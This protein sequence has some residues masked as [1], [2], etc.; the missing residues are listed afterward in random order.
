[1]KNRALAIVL[2]VATLISSVAVPV[3]ADDNI[4]MT[5]V[6]RTDIKEEKSLVINGF[7]TTNTVNEQGTD[8]SAT[9]SQ[10][11]FSGVLSIDNQGILDEITEEEI[12]KAIETYNSLPE[13][14][15]A[16]YKDAY[17]AVIRLTQQAAVSSE[18]QN[19]TNNNVNENNKGQENLVEGV[20]LENK[21]TDIL[22]LEK[23][24]AKPSKTS[25]N[26]ITVTQKGKILIE[27]PKSEKAVGYEFELTNTKKDGVGTVYTSD[28]NKIEIE[29]E[30][31]S[32][33]HVRVRSFNQNGAG[34]VY[35]AWSMPR[36]Y[37][38]KV[39]SLDKTHITA[40]E[41]KNNYASLTFSE[42]KN[43]DGIEVQAA[44]D[45]DFK[46]I[47]YTERT[48]NDYSYRT[49]EVEEG[50]TIY[51]RGRAYKWGSQDALTSEW[52]DVVTYVRERKVP[53]KT[54]LTSVKGN[55][56]RINVVWAKAENS[57]SYDVEIAE[58]KHF[59]KI[60]AS[61][62]TEANH[63]ENVLE[64]GKKYCVRVRGTR[65]DWP[66]LYYGEWSNV[67]NLT[68]NPSAVNITYLKSNDK[69]QATIKYKPLKSTNTSGYQIQYSTKKNFDN[70][71]IK[72]LA[73]K[74]MTIKKLKRGK[75]YYF[76]VRQYTVIEGKKVYGVWS[77][78][79]SV[80][81]KKKTPK[82]KIR[83]KT[84][85]WLGKVSNG[86]VIYIPGLGIKTKAYKEGSGVDGQVIVDRRGSCLY[87]KPGYYT[88]CAWFADHCDQGFS[89]L[90][91]AVPGKTIAY[92][93]RQDGKRKKFICKKRFWGHNTGD[94]LTTWG[95][96]SIVNANNGGFG[97]YT[98]NGPNWHNITITYWQPVL[99]L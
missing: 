56:N 38:M 86:S 81:V 82:A 98:C 2:S 67:K 12:N 94:D 24:P 49:H 34:T 16:L 8:T 36:Y 29:L 13:K 54:S 93:I 50:E 78:V 33:V 53:G 71:K 97:A 21:G 47:K 74:K 76:K 43:A 35:A 91:R 57:N 20:E 31:G 92:I 60:I 70:S 75:K 72:T 37:Y 64:T 77:Q 45:R 30:E 59:Q 27:A 28:T 42:V 26:K 32:S 84:N 19:N 80:K 23:A 9:T 17:D 11:P 46:N 89:G 63:W 66:N 41:Y 3:V 15:K 48:N 51:L 73:K 39:S 52:S 87:A 79:K 1:M 5:G 88:A 14:D 85:D 68:I 90:Y 99:D 7:S 4:N 22:V 62:T 96:K 61:T 44:A 58:D 40:S 65:Y 55:G 83:R 69:G 95:Y 10:N 25:V 18:E 6:D